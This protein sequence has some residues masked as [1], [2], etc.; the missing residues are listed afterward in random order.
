MNGL[1]VRRSKYEVL[2]EE[3]CNTL[4]LQNKNG[5]DIGS[6]LA[7]S[8]VMRNPDMYNTD[9]WV[10]ARVYPLLIGRTTDSIS[11]LAPWLKGRALSI[12]VHLC[13]ADLHERASSRTI[14]QAAEY[15]IG[16]ADMDVLMLKYSL[17]S[18]ISTPDTGASNTKY[19]SLL[20]KELSPLVYPSEPDMSKILNRNTT[21]I[22]QRY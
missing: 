17:L 1:A 12:A 18:I 16:L 14:E 3:W 15:L 22:N 19:Q 13:I 4:A 10:A 21:R 9:V 6:L 2:A 20:A 11:F 8:V 5:N 7:Q